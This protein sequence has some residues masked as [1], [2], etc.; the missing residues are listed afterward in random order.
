M[1]LVWT[2]LH[3]IVERRARKYHKLPRFHQHQYSVFW[4]TDLQK[5]KICARLASHCL[6]AEQKQESLEIATLLKHGFN[7]E[8][9]ALL[10]RNVANDE[11]WVG[12]FEP[13]LKSQSN[14]WRS[15]TSPRPKKFRQAQSKV[16]HSCVELSLLT[17]RGLQT[18]NG[19]WNRRETSGEVQPPRD[20]KNFD[21]YN[22]RSSKWYSL[23][24]ITEKSS[25]QIQ[26]HVEQLWQQR[27]IVTGCKN[28][29]EKCTKT[30]VTC[31]G[32]GHSFC[33]TM[34]TCTWG[35]LWPTCQVNTNGNCYLTRHTV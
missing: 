15:P 14:E 26:F 24:M 22:Q 21:K 34:H 3:K 13:K 30:D 27:T 5:R 32:I 8:G 11:T 7:V 19:S 10:Y 35:R 23:L 28:C 29:A 18:L 1:K 20:P 9:Q 17:K 25:L 31:S 12:D 33:T 4:Q 16:K 6:T 2:F